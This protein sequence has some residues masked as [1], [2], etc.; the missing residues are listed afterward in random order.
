MNYKHLEKLYEISQKINWKDIKENLKKNTENKE[1]EID[2][3]KHLMELYEKYINIPVSIKNTGFP[4]INI[5]E[6][7]DKYVFYVFATGF[8][9]NEIDL[10]LGK[11]NNKN[12]LKISG[13][14]KVPTKTSTTSIK[15][16]ILKKEWDIEEFERTFK[17]NDNVD[18]NNINA[19]YENSVLE[20]SLF[21]T[22]FKNDIPIH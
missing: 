8:N 9:K 15:P 18:I 14:S 6:Y 1:T 7:S 20:I 12:T 17:L 21:K 10:K 2:P 4:C 13:K 11:K 3:F 5:Y 19:H 16:T 22:K